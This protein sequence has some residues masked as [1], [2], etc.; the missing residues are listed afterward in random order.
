[1]ARLFVGKLLG[2][3]KLS[4]SWIKM[5]IVHE[6]IQPGRPQQNG[7]MNGCIGL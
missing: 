3:S 7:G 6:R 1:M 2:L 5:G 4:L